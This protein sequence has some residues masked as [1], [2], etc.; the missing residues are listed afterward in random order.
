VNCRSKT[1]HATDA[2]FAEDTPIPHQSPAAYTVD[3]RKLEFCSTLLMQICICFAG[4]LTGGDQGTHA[5]V[6][7]SLT[8]REQVQLL[9]A[10]FAEVTVLSLVGI[11]A[12][13]G[14]DVA[15]STTATAKRNVEK[16]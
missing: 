13:C 4:S 7:A 9:S 5:R 12:R 15:R 14:C 6:I 8:D 10:A 2:A 1:L 3:V 11:K 16:P